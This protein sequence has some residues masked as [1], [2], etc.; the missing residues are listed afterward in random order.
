MK[1]IN[2]LLVSLC[3]FSV[4]SAGYVLADAPGATQANVLR[5]YYIPKIQI[6][7]GDLKKM[8][9]PATNEDYAFY[10]SI[11]S[12][13]SVVIGRFSAGERVITLVQ[14][15]NADGTVDTYVDYYVESAKFSYSSSPAKKVTPERFKEMKVQIITGD[16]SSLSPNREGATY[17]L[18]LKSDMKRIRPWR[19]G[20]RIYQLNPDDT[21]DVMLDFYAAKDMYGADMVFEVKYRL[22]GTVR[23]MPVITHSVYCRN[24]KDPVALEYATKMISETGKQAG[25]R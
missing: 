5:G 13:S 25:L 24:S 23:I 22:S 3:L 10:Q 9:V 16:N 21:N 17:M 20:I 1:N 6:T 18:G 8:P 4:L 12:T 7:P 11:A 2:R 19:N 14:D 15:A